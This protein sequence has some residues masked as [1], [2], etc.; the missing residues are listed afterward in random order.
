MAVNMNRPER[1]KADIAASVDAFNRWFLAS[2]PAAFREQRTKATADVRDA[3]AKTG[4]FA[5]VSPDV[6]MNDPGILPTLRMATCPPLARDRLVG[7]A[8]VGRNLVQTMEKKAALP[9][10]MAAAEV[11][12]DL[13]RICRVVGRLMD[14]DICP[15]I[16]E[17]R[18]PTGDEARRA[19]MVVA[20]RLC[21]AVAHPIIRNA[22][23]ER[24][25]G[26]IRDWLESRGYRLLPTSELMEPTAMLPGTFAFRMTVQ[27]WMD[28]TGA[29]VVN[30]PVDVVIRSSSARAGDLPLFVEAKSA[31]DFANV[32][33]RRKEEA[34]K[35]RHMRKRYGPLARFV[36]FL[37]GYFDSGYLGYEA[38]EGIDWVWEH[39][40]G[41][42]A[43]FGL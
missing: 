10:R 37:G 41:D 42:L 35:A 40:V 9:E 33:K 38:A 14:A 28:G 6:L 26:R 1:W 22:Q 34:A 2:A 32:N 8:G 27:G 31:G 7:I 30:I 4:N 23:E 25:L 17:Q 24:Q 39:R 21:G 29:R 3:M 18:L 36:L 15:W 13:A 43:E 19:A 5:H 12:D 16:S 20:D 11:E